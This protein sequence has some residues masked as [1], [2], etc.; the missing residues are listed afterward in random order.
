M[1]AERTDDTADTLLQKGYAVKS[2]SFPWTGQKNQEYGCRT[3]QK[4]IDINGNNLCETLF[5]R[6]IRVRI[7]GILVMLV[8][9]TKSPTAI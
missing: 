6:M 8:M 7:S 1:N 9:M 2:R 3:D 5:S 4:G